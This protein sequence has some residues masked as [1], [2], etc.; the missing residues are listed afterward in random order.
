MDP[1]RQLQTPQISWLG[2]HA[3]LF[4]AP[5]ELSLEN[6][7]RI[8][9]LADYAQELNAIR[10]VVPGM[11]NLMLVFGPQLRESRLDGRP[12]RD[13]ALPA[14]FSP[15]TQPRRG[16]RGNGT[17]DLQAGA[18]SNQAGKIQAAGSGDSRLSV[19]GQFDNQRGSIVAAATPRS[20]RAACT[21]R[22]ARLPPPGNRR[23]PCM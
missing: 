14:S 17:L 5:G 10:G 3:V 21:T 9:A 19:T 22:A 16:P 4:E 2:T 20:R 13:I 23:C 11:N 1:A 15:G 6:Q 12:V 8:W 7:Q 18:L